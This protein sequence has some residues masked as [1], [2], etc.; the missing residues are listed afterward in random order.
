MILFL[1]CSDKY[2]SRIFVYLVILIFGT[3]IMSTS[4]CSYIIY[5]VTT[6]Y[7]SIF[8][9]YNLKYSRHTEFNQNLLRYLLYVCFKTKKQKGESMTDVRILH[10]HVTVIILLYSICYYQINKQNK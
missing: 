5:K 2:G 10:L 6:H 7:S 1:P 4:H 8:A 9:S 3:H